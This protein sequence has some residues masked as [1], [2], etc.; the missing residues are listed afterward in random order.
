MDSTNIQYRRVPPG[1]QKRNMERAK[2]WQRTS[3]SGNES[4]IKSE[5]TNENSDEQN[6]NTADPIECGFNQ[7]FSTDQATNMK[8]IMESPQEVHIEQATTSEVCSR[9]LP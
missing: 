8:E 6:K 3:T 7:T 9:R 2:A 1:Q 5:S 4:M